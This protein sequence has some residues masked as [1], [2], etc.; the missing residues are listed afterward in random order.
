MFSL[1]Y[2]GVKPGFFA[3]LFLL[4]FLALIMT[5]VHLFYGEIVLATREK[6]R[7]PGYAERYLGGGAKKFVA[8]FIIVGFYG[9]L[10]VYIVVGGNF[11]NYILSPVF[12]FPP[13]V[14]NLMFFLI[15]SL[16]VF[17]GLRFI[18]GL[19]LFMGVFLILIVFLF[20]FLGFKQVDINNLTTINWQNIIV[21]YG[22]I[23]YSL[24]GMAA[25]PEIRSMFGKNEKIF[26]RTIILG[27][28]IPAFLY[29][30][31][32]GTIIG[33]TGANTSANAISGLIDLLGE[34]AVLLGSIFGFLATITSFFILGLSLK[35]TYI[36]DFG[37]NKIWAWFIACFIPLIL[38]VLGFHNFILVITILGALM[39]LI[40]CTAIILIHRKINSKFPVWVHYFIVV[41]FVIGFSSTIIYSIFKHY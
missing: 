28:I 32:S 2:L 20:L 38:F 16:A 18:A 1:P 17:F 24:A 11:L 29:L 14:F 10:L 39:G 36:C 19:D 22:A 13:A 35:Q 5:L 7:L 33:L 30:I 8:F 34:K 21:P 9:S 41:V 6:Q 37:F 40:E 12:N 26:K 27:T 3:M 23:L 31:F 25:I 15:G 4:V